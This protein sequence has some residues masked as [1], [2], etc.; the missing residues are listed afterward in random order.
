VNDL[1]PFGLLGVKYD[2]F[3]EKIIA[4]LLQESQGSGKEGKVQEFAVD[5]RDESFLAVQAE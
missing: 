3:R 2:R 5:E 4:K 1:R